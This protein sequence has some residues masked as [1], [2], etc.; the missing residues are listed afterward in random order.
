MSASRA[1]I[2]LAGVLTAAPTLAQ[3]GPG[4]GRL[5]V[6][7]AEAATLMTPTAA[8]AEG[9]GGGMGPW[10]LGLVLL[11]AGMAAFGGTYLGL[12]RFSFCRLREQDGWREVTYRFRGKPM[13]VRGDVLGRLPGLMDEIQDLGARLR[14]TPASTTPETPPTEAAA[15]DPAPA[16]RRSAEPMEDREARYARARSLLRDGHD[17]ATV[18]TLTGLK[19][20]EIDLLRFAADTAAVAGPKVEG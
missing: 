12:R 5:E 10:S 4:P 14:R 13:R 19:T 11:V 20:A 8:W 3:T 7:A 9:G 6:L 15:A 1:A 18:R 17:T 16:E 2:G